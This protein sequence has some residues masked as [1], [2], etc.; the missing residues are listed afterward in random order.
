VE[1]IDHGLVRDTNLEFTWRLPL[2]QGN[3]SP[4]KDLNPNSVEYE[5]R[6]GTTEKGRGGSLTSHCAIVSTSVRH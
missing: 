6:A 1:G 3:L 4:G 2:G 5:A